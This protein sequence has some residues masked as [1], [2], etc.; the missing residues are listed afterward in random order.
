MKVS[1]AKEK[2]S[3]IYSLTFGI[4]GYLKSKLFVRRKARIEASPIAAS[5]GRTR[6]GEC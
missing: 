1:V 3:E 6:V 4:I 5:Q 2:W